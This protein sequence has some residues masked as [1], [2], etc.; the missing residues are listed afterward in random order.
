MSFFQNP[1]SEEFRASIP[2]GDRQYN[3]SFVVPS[4]R[5]QPNAM[6]A[7]NLEPYD[8][9]T[10][11]NF[12]INFAI[13]NSEFKNYAAITVDVS[14]TSAATTSAN[15]IAEALN[16]DQNFASWFTAMVVE[17]NKGS[18]VYRVGIKANTSK[19]MRVYI[20][21]AGAEQILRFNKYA[22]VAELPSYFAR[23]TIDNRFT[24]SD[25][26]AALVLLDESDITVDQPIITDAGFI[27]A[28]MKEDWEL[29]R[30]RVGIFDFQK[31][32]YDG[33]NRISTIIFYP[34]GAG[35]GDLA[36]K[37]FYQYDGSSDRVTQIA[38]IPYVLESG[39]LITP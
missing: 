29:L 18:G 37:T 19:P 3:L 4:N 21:N 33:S 35:V 1:F 25:S 26:L 6:I 20:T 36:K 12:T 39:D 31:L 15:E 28:D 2:L 30:G 14:G 32:A 11:P 17:S 10:Y 9:S 5:N 16:D 27:V 7:W 13:D 8:L 24:F 38:E 23:H 22:G 34:A